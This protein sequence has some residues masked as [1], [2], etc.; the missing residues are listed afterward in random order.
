MNIFCL[1]SSGSKGKRAEIMM[2]RRH[3][4]YMCSEWMKYF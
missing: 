2:S 1:Q 3:M 4:Q